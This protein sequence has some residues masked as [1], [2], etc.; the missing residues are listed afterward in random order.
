VSLIAGKGNAKGQLDDVGSRLTV[1]QIRE[2]TINPAEM[3]KKTNAGRK[4][5]MR[6]YPNLAKGDVEALVAYVLSLKKT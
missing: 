1:D 5:P 2:W 6:A 4:P 3:T